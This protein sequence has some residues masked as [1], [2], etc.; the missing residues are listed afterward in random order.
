MPAALDV[1]ARIAAGRML[2]SVVAGVVL[3]ILAWS[4]LRLAPRTNART[5]V[6]VWLS[7]LVAIP[8]L[9]VAA[10]FV[11]K[12]SS[13]LADQSAR[14]VVPDGWAFGILSA[15]AFIASLALLRVAFGLW[16]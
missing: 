16:R 14:I 4:L 11:G 7:V 10:I 1:F 2:N 3:T 6:A 9:S 5:R 13:A 15:W 12:T 8:G